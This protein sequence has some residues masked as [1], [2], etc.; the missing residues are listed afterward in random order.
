MPDG[1]WAKLLSKL[2]DVS[3]YLAIMIGM[4][5]CFVFIYR[6]S[7]KQ[8]AKLV[9]ITIKTLKEGNDTLIKALESAY[10]S[11]TKGR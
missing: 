1:E 8:H 5:A 9:E 7:I 4:A 3:P 6:F 2:I 10:A 11:S